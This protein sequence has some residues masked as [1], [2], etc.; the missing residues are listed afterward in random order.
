MLFPLAGARYRADTARS[1]F[2]DAARRS[3]FDAPEFRAALDVDRHLTR[4]GPSWRP[5]NSRRSTGKLAHQN[6]SAGEMD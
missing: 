5:I 4:P 2:E 3:T 6:H 1:P